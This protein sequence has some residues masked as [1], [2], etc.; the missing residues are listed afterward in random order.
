MTLTVEEIEAAAMSLAERERTHLAHLARSVSHHTP[1]IEEAWRDEVE[2][3][4][5][6]QEAGE[7]EDIPAEALYLELRQR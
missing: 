2:Q 3:R 4:I 1:A 6:L 5:A 7:I